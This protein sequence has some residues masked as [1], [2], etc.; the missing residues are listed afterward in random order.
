MRCLIATGVRLLIV[1][2]STTVF[3]Q[4]ET[5]VDSVLNSLKLLNSDS[6][7][8]HTLLDLSFSEPPKLGIIYATEAKQIAMNNGNEQNVALAYE[9]ISQ[10]HRELGNYV[11]AIKS[12]LEALKIYDK[13]KQ[14]NKTALMQLQIGSHFG[15]AKDYTSS[16]RYLKLALNT[17]SQ[18]NDSSQ[19]VLALIN[20]GETY[21]LMNYLD[22]SK[23]CF[24][25]SLEI[26]KVLNM[27]NVQGYALGNLGLVNAQIGNKNTAMKELKCAIDI[28][29]ELKDFYSVSVYQSELGKFL[30][31]EGDKSNGERLL[32]AS[33]KMA[34][35]E[36]MKEQ[37]CSIGQD[38]YQFYESQNN[39]RKALYFFK[40]YKKYNDSIINIDNVRE[41]EKIHSSYQLNKKEASIQLLE[42]KNRN[43]QKQVLILLISVV[44]FL[45]LALFLYSLYKQ[46]KE[47]F[48]QILLQ[49]NII[50]TREKEKVILLK[51]LN[52]RVKN[53]LQMVASLLQIQSSH[54]PSGFGSDAI[55]KAKQRVE[56]LLLLHK[57][58]YNEKVDM[59][60]NLKKYINDLVDNLILNNE[61]KVIKVVE[62]IS[63]KI[64]MNYA[65]PFGL[66]VNELITNSLKYATVDDGLLQLSVKLS[67]N[68]NI[69]QLV[70]ADN[71][72]QDQLKTKVDKNKSMGINL[73]HQLTK[74]IK[75]SIS[76]KTDHG[77]KWTLLI[78]LKKIE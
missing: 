36:R 31:S 35:K 33:F 61:V 58:L 53:N 78:D 72:A 47:A 50:E 13:L 15:M 39:Y 17:L 24:K 30:I 60:V 38:L 52:H 32:I 64:H 34:E 51:E 4:Y 57:K 74:Q 59:Q 7:K 22:S 5:K 6:V 44:L 29:S 46:R 42:L 19:I 70:I 65:I 41:I 69:L 76:L 2:V 20:L 37:I 28:L 63:K 73:V 54:L 21:R 1:F 26:N 8:F 49:K 9:Y 16:I 68:K 43:K 71:G 3:A 10:S 67:E 56:A 14:E 23:L 25:E 62:L 77:W 45:T 75:G 18:R 27:E 11:E 12:S 40:Q 48:K 66:I 55:K